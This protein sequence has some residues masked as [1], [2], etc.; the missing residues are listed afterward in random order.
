MDA[1]KKEININDLIDNLIK[2]GEN[3]Q[4]LNFWQGLYDHLD[5]ET[6]EKLLVNMLTELEELE[7]IR[8]GRQ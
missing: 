8:G 4:E 1:P 5:R 6:K 3:Q 7:R 2:H